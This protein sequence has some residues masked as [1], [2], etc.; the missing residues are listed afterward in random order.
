MMWGVLLIALLFASGGAAAATV[1]YRGWSVTYEK[2]G[3][4][5]PWGYSARRGDFYIGDGPFETQRIAEADMR[6]RVDAREDG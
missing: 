2:G 6:M 4:P 3:G 5:A 1:M